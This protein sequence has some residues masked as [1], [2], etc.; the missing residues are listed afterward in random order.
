MRT[1]VLTLALVLCI[2]HM[3]AEAS[4]QQTGVVGQAEI[5]AALEDHHG[6]EDARRA[7]V[8]RVLEQPEVRRVARAMGVDTE[9]LERAAGA[10]Q[11]ER[12]ATAA[13]QARAIESQLAGGQSITISA[14]TLIIILL[15]VILVIV[16]D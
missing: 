15:L 3:P 2:I 11:G 14:T 4:G 16:A 12:L 1:T 13:E 10:A 9:R 7:V 8:R 6:G 5:E